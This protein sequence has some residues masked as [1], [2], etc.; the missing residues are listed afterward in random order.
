MPTIDYMDCFPTGP[1]TIAGQYMR[2][3]WHPVQRAD[4]IKSGW[5]KPIRIMSEDFTLYRGESG[6]PQVVEF[7]CPHRQSQ[8]SV[9]WVE[10][11]SLALPLSRLE[12]RRL[13]PMH[14]AAGRERVVHRQS[15]HPQLS[16]GRISG[17]DLRLLRRGCAAAAA[18]FSGFRKR[19]LMGG[20]LCPALQLSQQH[21]KRSGAYSVHAQRVRVFSPPAA[22][23][24]RRCARR[25]PNGA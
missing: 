24:S 12:V 4:D 1:G 19:R 10:G 5:A 16:H 22:R 8:L 15:A 2:K 11:D 3:F 13:R 23:D 14:R 20:D 9:G 6:K 21:R 18:A 17:H 25:K 7:R